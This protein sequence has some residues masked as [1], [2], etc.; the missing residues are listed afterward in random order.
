MTAELNGTERR[1][2][3]T[4]I[5]RGILP[6][7]S[8]PDQVLMGHPRHGAHAGTACGPRACKDH[9]SDAF[10]LLE[11]ARKIDFSRE[12]DMTEGRGV[13]AAAQAWG[14]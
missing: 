11:C 8:G 9:P 2:Q 14:R 7:E 5:L 3:T 10:R 4:Q 12:F 6:C 13:G 1:V